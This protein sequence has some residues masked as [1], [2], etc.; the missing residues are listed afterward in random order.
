[1][2][3]SRVSYFFPE[4][5]L[6]QLDENNYLEKLVQK[7]TELQIQKDYLKEEV[8]Q[9]CQKDTGFLNLQSQLIQ[10]VQE[11]ED[12]LM[13]PVDNLFKFIPDQQNRV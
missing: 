7:I 13:E 6:K 9:F 12:V 10:D 3:L 11:M 8:D 4:Q 1:M 2:R 5:E